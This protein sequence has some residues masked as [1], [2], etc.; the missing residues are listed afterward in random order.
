MTTVK[1]FGVGKKVVVDADR[2]CALVI[3]AWDLSWDRPQCRAISD[4]PLSVSIANTTLVRLQQEEE[5]ENSIC[6]RVAVKLPLIAVSSLAML[7]SIN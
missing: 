2:G 6:N 1:L 7:L 5:R 4:V 3:A